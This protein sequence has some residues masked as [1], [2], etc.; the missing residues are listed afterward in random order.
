M[1]MVKSVS[2]ASVAALTPPTASRASRLKA[3]IAP[4]TVGMHCKTSYMRRSR[5][6]PITY[7]MCCQR[8]SKPRRLPTFVLPET[9]PI[10]DLLAVAKRATS[11]RT[12]PGSKTVSDASAPQAERLMK[13]VTLRPQFDDAVEVFAAACVGC[14]L[15]RIDLV[16]S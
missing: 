5:L 16:F 12:A 6:N 10:M 13:H 3:P 7:S 4:G 15:L 9:A 1:A 2:S 8:P 11:A 14:H